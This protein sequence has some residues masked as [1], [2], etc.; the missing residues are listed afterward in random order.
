MNQPPIIVD[1]IDVKFTPENGLMP[2]Q[3]YI[4]GHSVSDPTATD[5]ISFN[6]SVHWAAEVGYKLQYLARRLYEESLDHST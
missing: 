4:R 5:E 3:L 6:L 1:D 2:V